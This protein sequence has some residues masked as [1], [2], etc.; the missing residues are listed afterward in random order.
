VDVTAIASI[1]MQGDLARLESISHNTANVL[2][3]GFKRQIAITSGFAVQLQQGA[4]QD[5]RRNAPFAMPA[6]ALVPVRTM[7]DPSSGSLRHTGDYQDVAIEGPA[8]FEVSTP[9]GPAYTKAG[10]L[11]IDVQGRLVNLQN[12]PIMGIGGEIRLTNTPFT[13]AANGDV[14]Q[15]GRVVGRLKL[16]Q[17]DHAE[18]MSP[19]GNGIY[20]AGSAQQTQD[21]KT[22]STLRT[23]FLEGSNVSS[24]Q[25]MVRLTETV[26]HFESLQRLVQG[27][28]ETLEKTIRKLG[29]F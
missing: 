17:F 19:S 18:G 6:G 5:V 22:P 27:Y 14:Q 3:P 29:E 13:I 8:F 23:G 4:Q 9:T 20:L 28:D 26:R 16:V 11:H 10:S 15:D 25:E 12:L 7:I 24:P 1:G 2:T 21:A